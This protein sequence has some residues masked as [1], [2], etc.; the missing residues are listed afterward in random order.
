MQSFVLWQILIDKIEVEVNPIL[1]VTII[2][3]V[4]DSGQCKITL[5]SVEVSKIGSEYV[6]QNIPCL[7]I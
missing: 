2:K 5:A 1:L 7:I 4:F 3:V 6:L